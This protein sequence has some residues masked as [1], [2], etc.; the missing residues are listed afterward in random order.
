[1]L[2]L[3]A[4]CVADAWEGRWGGAPEGARPPRPRFIHSNLGSYDEII[5]MS[6]WGCGG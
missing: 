6:R 4:A 5:E 1:M 3:Q 2:D